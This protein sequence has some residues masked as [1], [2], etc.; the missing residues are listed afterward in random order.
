MLEASAGEMRAV[1]YYWGGWG[2]SERIPS[3]SE[4]TG[5]IAKGTGKGKTEGKGK[6]LTA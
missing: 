5:V 2:V 4:D 1:R 3:G 6:E